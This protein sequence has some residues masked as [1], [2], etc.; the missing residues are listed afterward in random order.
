MENLETI[1]LFIDENDFDEGIDAISLVEFPAIEENFVSLSKQEV[2]LRTIDED[3]RLVI[4]LALVPNKK[5]YRRNGEHEYNIVFGEETVRKA[6]ELY[7]KRL[8]LHNATV[9]HQ[10]AVKGVYL[11]E[12]WFVDN[13]EMDKTNHY[14]LNPVKGAWAVGLRV[15]NDQVWAD[16]KDGKYLGFSIEGFFSEALSKETTEA[17]TREEELLETIIKALQ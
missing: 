6:G 12:S 7:L 9:E 8:K 1:E 17:K 3:K 11:A 5:I 13:P 15:E 16:I 2:Q 14:G 4:G 10:E